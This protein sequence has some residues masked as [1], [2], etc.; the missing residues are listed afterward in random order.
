MIPF[1]IGDGVGS[2]FCLE[3]YVNDCGRIRNRIGLDDDEED[4]RTLKPTYER[5]GSQR[6]Q[7]NDFRH[8]WRTTITVVFGD[9]HG[10][11][12]GE[13]TMARQPR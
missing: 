1:F 9:T 4:C 6:L 11:G 3:H 2:R 7:R 10:R 13:S 5:N 12:N 8:G